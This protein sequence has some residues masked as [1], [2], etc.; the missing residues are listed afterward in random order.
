MR[1]VAIL[2]AALSMLFGG[3][4]PGAPAKSKAGKPQRFSVS[5]K[6]GI[7]Y[8][9]GRVR[10]PTP[11][12]IKLR[13]DLYKPVTKSKRRRP[14]V[15]LIAGGGF[16]SVSRGH[17]NIVRIARGFARRGIVVASIEY[18]L[19][20]Q[21]P[22]NSARVAPLTAV[23]APGPI[24]GSIVAAVDDTLTAFDW[25]RAHAR[26]HRIDLKRLGV[27]GESAGAITANHVAYV[28]DEYGVKAPRVR[29]VGDLWG[30]ILINAVAPGAQLERGEAPLFAVHGSADTVVPTVLDEQIVARARAVGV[31]VEYHRVEGGG[32][33]ADAV[34]FFT[35]DLL[36]GQTAFDRLLR[37]ADRR[38][39]GRNR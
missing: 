11:G 12:R 20:G 19:S 26:R 18:R 4:A 29:F 7:V 36:P 8:G 32:H 16:V 31:P 24:F 30:A 15:V 34:G 5:V 21:D 10:K 23:V 1:R 14:A 38:L 25:V 22:V 28:L 3:L 39:L 17:P 13:L 33:G 9:H 27:V 6:K 2:A 35:R 37:F